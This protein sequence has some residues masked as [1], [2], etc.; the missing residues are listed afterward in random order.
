MFEDLTVLG[1]GMMNKSKGLDYDHLK[2]TLTKTAYWHAAT[3]TLGENV[4]EHYIY[5][6]FW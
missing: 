3:A 6:Y 4:S 5:N 1:F 2:M